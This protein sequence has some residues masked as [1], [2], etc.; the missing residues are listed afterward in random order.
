SRGPHGLPIDPAQREELL[1]TAAQTVFALGILANLALSVGEAVALFSLFA[2][3]FVL[4]ALLPAT[5]RGTEL[6]LLSAVYLLFGLALVVRHRHELP[7]RLRD[8]LV[9]PYAA[10]E[11]PAPAPEPGP[12]PRRH[13]GAPG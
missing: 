11:A 8:G 2:A 5:A 7:Q 1:L 12:G 13:P 6:L 4:H 3:Q 10:L 9:T